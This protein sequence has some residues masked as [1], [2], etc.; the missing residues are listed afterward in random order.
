VRVRNLPPNKAGKSVEANFNPESD[1]LRVSDAVFAHDDL[2]FTGGKQGAAPF[3]SDVIPH[4]VGHAVEMKAT[5]DS[6][7]AKNRYVAIASKK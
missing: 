3:S 6:L 2:A 1:I 5:R 4:E 7:R